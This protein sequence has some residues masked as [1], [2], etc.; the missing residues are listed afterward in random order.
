MPANSLSEKKCLKYLEMFILDKYYLLSLLK[1]K[2]YG[3]QK[4]D[5]LI[6]VII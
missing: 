4:M 6:I 2:R 1:T 5:M 3:F